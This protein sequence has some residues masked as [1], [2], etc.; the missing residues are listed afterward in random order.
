MTMTMSMM[1]VP[2]SFQ[3]LALALSIHC[4]LSVFASA[5]PPS[6]CLAA[7]AKPRVSLNIE[8][9]QTGSNWVEPGR[10]DSNRAAYTRV[11]SINSYVAR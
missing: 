7:K 11:R 3:P 4:L 2:L 9:G 6:P 5:S 10:T 1:A 8:L